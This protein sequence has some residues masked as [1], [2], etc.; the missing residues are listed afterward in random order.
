[1]VLKAAEKLV[2]KMKKEDLLI[3]LRDEIKKLGLVGKEDEVNA[4]MKRIEESGFK[5]I[6]NK[7]GVTKE[8]I[9]EV[10]KE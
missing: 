2:G 3:P 8:D 10:F 5:S 9:E 1:M 7:L 4:A 6:F